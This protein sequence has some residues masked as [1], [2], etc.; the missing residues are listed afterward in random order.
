MTALAAAFSAAVLV[1]VASAWPAALIAVLLALV[2]DWRPVGPPRPA[3]RHR[4]ASENNAAGCS[5]I[6]A[7]SFTTEV[8]P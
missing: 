6:P 8:S 5:H 2:I 1:V 4:C 3:A 7:S